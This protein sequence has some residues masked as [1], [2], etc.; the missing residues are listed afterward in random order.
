[1]HIAE[2]GPGITEDQLQALR[3]P[4]LIIATGQDVIHPL[5]HAEKLH[6]LISGSILRLIAPKGVDKARYLSEFRSTLLS[7]LEDHA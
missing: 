3:I 4:T 2:D 6:A 5:A 7:F 1:M